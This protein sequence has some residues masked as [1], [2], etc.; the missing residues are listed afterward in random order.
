MSVDFT[1]DQKRYL[2]GFAAGFSARGGQKTPPAQAQPMGPDAAHFSAQDRVVAAGGKLTDQEKWKREEHPFD[3]WPRLVAQAK[4]NAPPKPADNFRWRYYGLFYVAPAQESYMCRLRIP[5]GALTHWQ[6]AGLADLAEKF[7]GGY[8]HV[9]TRANIQIREIAPK[10]A[11]NVVEAIQDLGLWSKGSGAD[12]I[13]NITGTP[14]A[15]VDPQELI[16]TRPYARAMHH[17]ILNDR[18][19]Y[20]L[21]RKFNIA[22]DGA[23]L[24]GALEDTNDIGFQAVAVQDGYGVAPGVYFRLALGGITGHKDFARDTGVIVSPD[25]AVEV[26]D[27]ILRVF[28]E[29][30]DRTNRAK[31]RLKYVLDAWGFD[32]FLAAVEDKLGRKLLRVGTNAIDARPRQDRAAHIGVH[33]QKQPGFNWIGVALPVGRLTPEQARGLAEIA[34]QF[35]DGGLRLTVWQNVLITGVADGCVAD[36]VAMIE[37]LGLSTQ[38]SPIRAGLI[39]CTGNSGCRFAAADTKRHAEEIAAYCETATPIDTPINIHLTGCHH[40]CAQH[41]IGDIGLIATRVPVNDEGETVEGYHILVGGGFAE[42]AG[43][44]AEFYQNVKA[45]EAPEMVARILRAYRENRSNADETFVA[46][47]RR[48][49]IE[50]LR[51]LANEESMA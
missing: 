18:S 33:P 20:G 43:F 49:D 19:L 28:I 50:T 51:R 17:H 34:R 13:R 40:S 24:I 23:G 8:L 45:E 47:A 3:A 26:A 21:P 5:N 39:A 46:F 42:D 10:N 27:K 41:Y 48:H 38:A 14:T 29:H 4:E 2:E 32:K 1:L 15:G 25:D 16:D 9:T 44:A 35:G 11:T 22:F 37:A 31:A 36:A 6:F 30:G 7:G 12:N